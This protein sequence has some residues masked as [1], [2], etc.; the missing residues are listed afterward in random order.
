[1]DGRVKRGHVVGGDGGGKPREAAQKFL[2]AFFEM[3]GLLQKFECVAK[4]SWMPACA[5]M[6]GLGR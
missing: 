2:R 4:K 5:G 1:V 3:R 6:T